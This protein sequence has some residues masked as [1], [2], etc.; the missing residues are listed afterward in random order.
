[1]QIKPRSVL[2]PAA[3]VALVSC[4]GPSS[5]PSPAPPAGI[6]LSGRILEVLPDGTRRPISAQHVTVAVEVSSPLD[7]QRGGSIPVAADG[8]YRLSGVP[9]ARFV[10]I[11]GVD[12]QRAG[13]RFCGTHTITRGDTE[14]NVPLFLP[15]A[16]LPTPTLSGQV[17][18]V[19]NGTRT[20]LANAAVY[21]QSRG[22]G[23]DV[24]ENTDGDGRYSLCG[25]PEMPGT[26]YLVCGNESLAYSQPVDNSSGS[27]A[28]DIDAT[29]FAECLL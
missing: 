22:Y 11:T 10:K 13:H 3:L 9:D 24:S 16:A 2:L 25:I 1:M 8:S 23:P 12:F 18:T 27:A 6:T 4:A 19:N 7:P 17:F 15:G 28:I 21:Y 5:S 26:L 14:L 29:E 20:P